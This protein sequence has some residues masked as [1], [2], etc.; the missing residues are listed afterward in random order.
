MFSVIVP[1]Y[2]KVKYIRHAIQTICDQKYT[3]FEVIVV[4]DGS[5]DG[6]L[7]ELEDAIA[8]IA[9]STIDFV[10]ITQQNQGVSTARNNGVKLAKY[11]YIA[12]L[13]A[14]DW[15]EPTYL[16]EMKALI[17]R[18]PEAGIYGSSYYKVKDGVNIRANIGVSEDFTDGL[19][20]YC[21]VYAKTFYMPLWTG[22][23]I[24]RK[25]VYNE[26]RGFKAN[27][28]L[29]ED[30]DLWI[31]VALRYPVAFLNKPLAYYDQDVSVVDKAVVKQKIY[32]PESI[33]LFNLSYL[34]DEERKNPDLKKLL[35]LLRVYTLE[36]YYLQGEYPELV[37]RE[38]SKV[39]FSGQ[40]RYFWYFYHL[41]AWVIRSVFRVYRLLKK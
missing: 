14:D 21:Q 30:F 18:Y 1:L 11:P 34:D 31:R 25:E 24:I 8:S 20:N 13:D 15:W 9:V 4:D 40:A 2:N 33:Y 16:E 23:T 27:L 39:D 28:V 35:D 3:S 10:V 36:R 17:E 19:I 6:S 12:F 5:T 37:K 32:S 41:P 38:L 26:E 29:G 7:Q 22:A